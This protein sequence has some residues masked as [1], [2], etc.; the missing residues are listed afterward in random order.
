MQAA[1]LTVLPPGHCVFTAP[2]IPS[3]CVFVP[4]PALRL[5]SV[6]Q[7]GEPCWG[8]AVVQASQSSLNEDFFKKPHCRDAGSRVMSNFF[9]SYSSHRQRLRLI[10]CSSEEEGGN[11]LLF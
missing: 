11:S 9:C 2:L 10:T 5:C 4:E 7:E 1:T 3:P 6:P 8:T